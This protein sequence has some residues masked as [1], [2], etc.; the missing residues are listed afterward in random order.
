MTAYQCFNACVEHPVSVRRCLLLPRSGLRL[1]AHSWKPR[2]EVLQYV[3]RVHQKP[4]WRRLF[5]P[6]ARDCFPHIHGLGISEL[7]IETGVY[8]VD[9]C[10]AN[11][12]NC[13]DW[14][15]RAVVLHCERY[16]L[17]TH[18]AAR[19]CTSHGNMGRPLNLH[20]LHLV[21]YSLGINDERRALEQTP[22]HRHMTCPLK[23]TTQVV[24]YWFQI[25]HLPQLCIA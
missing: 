1:E 4:A 25:R 13:A 19:T 11:R 23:V 5:S 12:T 16:P 14:R 9:Q 2:G 21:A 8:E 20:V 24:R 6:N 10:R 18:Q 22:E 15:I 3:Q 7:N 17:P